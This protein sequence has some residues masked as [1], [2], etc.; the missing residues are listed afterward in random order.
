M[1][2]TNLEPDQAQ[3]AARALLD[4]CERPV[5]L[6]ATELGACLDAQPALRAAIPSV[7]GIR[8]LGALIPETVTE[9]S[10]FDVERARELAQVFWATRAYDHAR[11]VLARHRFV[12]LTGP[13]EVGKTTI[14]QCSRSRS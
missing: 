12:V 8:E 4:Q 11:Q 6:G 9:R 5:I 2:L 1:A 13:P 7:L 3:D 10:C 14:A